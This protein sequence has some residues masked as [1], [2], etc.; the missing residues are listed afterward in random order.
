MLWIIN[1]SCGASFQSNVWI[2]LVIALHTIFIGLSADN[3]ECRSNGGAA[4][5][6]NTHPGTLQDIQIIYTNLVINGALLPIISTGSYSF[7]IPLNSLRMGNAKLSLTDSGGFKR[8]VL[9]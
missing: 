4:G 5:L 7:P 1:G 6:A 3:L 9:S 8:R 2:V